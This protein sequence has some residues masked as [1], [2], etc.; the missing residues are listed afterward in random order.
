KLT[1]DVR[2]EVL[3][4]ANDETGTL[5]AKLGFGLAV[6][7]PHIRTFLIMTDVFPEASQ[8]YSVK[9]LPHTVVNGRYHIEG[10]IEEKE[11]LQHISAALKN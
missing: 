5:V 9:V 2:L 11:M 10:H 7:N 3:T 4:A 6:V 1:Q 8:R